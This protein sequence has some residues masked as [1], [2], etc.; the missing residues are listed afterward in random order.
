MSLGTEYE[1]KIE[2]V[3]EQRQQKIKFLLGYKMKI[4]SWRK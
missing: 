3:Q 2:M 4:V 1:V